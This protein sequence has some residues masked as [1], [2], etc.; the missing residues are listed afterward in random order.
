MNFKFLMIPSGIGDL[1]VVKQRLA[2]YEAGEVAHIENIM[3]HE[4]RSRDHRRLRQLEEI[5]VIETERTEETTRDLQ[6]TERFE[7]QNESKRTIKSETRFEAGVEVSAGFGP[8]KTNASAKYASNTSKEEADS[9]STRYAK[10][11]GN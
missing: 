4:T 5:S 1:K 2:R 9:Q 7:L 3:A 11:I 8:V 6:S 10:N